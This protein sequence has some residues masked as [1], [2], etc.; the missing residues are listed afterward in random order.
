MKKPR[1]AVILPVHNEEKTIK[2]V[3][4]AILSFDLFD[5]II[6]VT[7]GTTDGSLEILEEYD[8][9]EKIIWLNYKR[10][11]GKGFALA[12]GVKKS[13]ADIVVFFDT[14]QNKLKK[15]HLE[16]M[17]GPLIAGE[18]D[19]IIGD[20]G[21]ARLF[22]NKVCGNRSYFRRDLLPL[23]KEMKTK[24]RGIELFL[25]HELLRRGKRIKLVCLPGL[26]HRLKPD[27]RSAGEALQDYLREGYELAVE[28]ARQKKLS[29]E[30]KT[31]F[32]RSQMVVFL[33]SYARYFRLP[34]KKIRTLVNDFLGQL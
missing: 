31:E 23:L 1:L 29:G 30:E 9:G 17:V 27:K 2:G 11:R 5:E 4:D 32:I 6:A 15:E 18:A 16:K 12:R 33:R 13:T 14:D 19:C 10:N 21:V 28:Y 20:H 34:A 25:N 3:I 7:D 24:R 26:K 8:R 22:N